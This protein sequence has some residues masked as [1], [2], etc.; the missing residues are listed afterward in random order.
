[1]L[2]HILPF[3]LR[4]L[5][6]DFVEDDADDPSRDIIQCL[7]NFIYLIRVMRDPIRTQDEVHGLQHRIYEW[8]LL[9]DLTFPSRSYVGPREVGTARLPA[10]AA[11]NHE[12]TAKFHALHHVVLWQFAAGG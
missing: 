5:L 9:A 7:N 4:D 6:A 10:T 3:C 11:L 2:F 8:L 1:M 12:T